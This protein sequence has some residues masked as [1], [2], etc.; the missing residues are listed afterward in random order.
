MND[1]MLSII[2]P[3]KNRIYTLQR[4]VELFEK[5]DLK[6]VELVIQDNSDTCE[7]D[8]YFNNTSFGPNV[9][10]YRSSE[11]LSFVKN[12]SLAVEHASGEYLICIGDDDSVLPNIVDVANYAKK[13]N[14][15]CIVGPVTSIYF[16]PG[17]LPGEQFKNGKLMFLKNNK[18]T[19]Q[20]HNISKELSNFFNHGCINYLDYFFPKIYHGIVKKEVMNNLKNVIGDYFIGL[21]PDISSCIGLSLL[22]VKTL[23]ANFVFTISGVGKNSGSSDSGSAKHQGMLADAPHFRG[24][25]NYKWNEMIP[26]YYSVETIWAETALTTAMK[27]KTFNVKTFDVEPLLYISRTKYLEYFSKTNYFKKH[28]KN[29]E[30]S[31]KKLF[32]RPIFTKF[33][34]KLHKKIVLYD[35]PDIIV[36]TEIVSK[37]L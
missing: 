32:L 13:N 10:I 1:Y 11:T 35:I 31:R 17:S 18:Q 34:N 12:F 25:D 6:G 3:T 9:S 15:D 14:V 29:I 33:K 37:E 2:V 4:L 27:F 7:A 36:A 24:H 23:F 8:E 21:T 20:R 30:R 5:Q 26:D 28:K 22:N 19:Y 16:W